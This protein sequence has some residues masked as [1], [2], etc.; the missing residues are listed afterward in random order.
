MIKSEI[1]H[2]K[3]LDLSDC[4]KSFARESVERAAVREIVNPKCQTS[5]AY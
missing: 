5:F 2:L 1:P 3:K 4:E